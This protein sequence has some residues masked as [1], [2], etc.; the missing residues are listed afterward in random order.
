MTCDM[1]HY[2][3]PDEISLDNSHVVPP[4]LQLFVGQL[5]HDPRKGV[6]I[7]Q[8][9][10][11]AARPRSCIM[12]LL[13]GLGVQ[14]HRQHGSAQ[15][16]RQLARWGFSVSLD[17]VTRYLQSVM[18]CTNGWLPEE[19]CEARF[20][21]FVADNVDHNIQTVDG[22]KTFHG[23]GIIAA[24]CFGPGM[25]PV[26]RRK[27]PRTQKRLLV[28]DACCDKGVPLV[29]YCSQ[30]GV[31]LAHYL[32]KPLHSLNLSQA[33]PVITK[34]TTLWHAGGL[35]AVWDGQRP[36]WSGYMQSVC[37]GEHAVTGVVR[38]MPILDLNPSDLTCIY[39]TLLFVAKQAG[40]LNV[41]TPCITFD[42]PL[43]IKAVDIVQ[44]EQLNIVIRLGG[45]HTL[46]NF[47]GALGDVMRGSGL[48]EAFELLYGK[49]TVEHV[50]SG[51]AYVRAVRGHMI[52]HSA[53]TSLLMQRLMPDWESG[54][55]MLET[56]NLDDPLNIVHLILTQSDV[57]GL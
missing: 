56:V 3:N 52:V 6:A 28:A 10:I 27:I 7:A 8:A 35:P 18:Q 21:Q 40:Y 43:Y 48:E 15:L 39:S 11:Q 34:V 17:E 55:D 33:L 5:V 16:V 53:L 45:F 54:I 26:A 2:P 30:S 50:M 44:N 41:H 1:G 9:V 4:L 51:K 14:I 32:L 36:M 57:C 12:P 19:C 49:K 25:S 23:M 31:G 46:M 47:M 38:M 20:T 13:F 29:S 37:H 22:H 24:S 42:Q